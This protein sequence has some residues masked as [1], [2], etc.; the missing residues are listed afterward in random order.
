MRGTVLAVV[1]LVAVSGCSGEASRLDP[2]GPGS[3]GSAAELA[4]RAAH[5]MTAL[6]D[7]DLLVVGGCDVDG[8]SQATASAFVVSGTAV[9]RVADVADARDAHTAV[10]LADGR[11]LVVGGFAGEGSPPLR[12]AEIFDPESGRWTTTGS[13][14][15]GRGGHTAALLGDGRVMVAGGWVG[16][17]TYTDTTEIFDPGSGRFEPGPRLPQ[18][19]DGLAAAA[20]PGG[21]VLVVG[22]QV[23]S[24]VASAQAAV[25]CPDGTLDEVEPLGTARFK[26]GIAV[27]DSG[28][29][30]VV[31][32][33]SDDT[34]LL[35]GTEV[36]DPTSR[37]FRAGPDLVSG[38]Y[39]LSDAVV[40][41]PG[42]RA[43][44]A[45]GG[46]GVEI[47]DVGAGRAIPVPAL[48]GGRR[49]F[50]TVGVTDGRVVLVGGYDETIRLTRTYL[51]APVGDL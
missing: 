8:C 10:P 33:T 51:T 48:D 37:D 49:S 13:L 39:K 1:L 4:A 3:Y 31:G 28:Q 25:I 35:R 36:F 19:V 34:D 15:L 41:L 27:L 12:S 21:C 38:R 24:Q 32:G 29:V 7:G 26:H 5:T 14:A 44:V 43:V 45:G 40:A 47:V 18:A 16:P 46:E 17:S 6:P 11:V 23:R 20:L 50:S 2:S 30:L 42:D 22:G 9:S